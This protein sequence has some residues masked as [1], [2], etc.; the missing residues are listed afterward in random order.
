MPDAMLRM[1][2]AQERR[3]EPEQDAHLEPDVAHQVVVDG[4]THADRLDDGR[5]VVVGQDHDRG[6]LGHLGARDAHGHADV[7]LLERRRVVHA[8]TGHGHDV[9]LRLEHVHQVD[10]VLGR[11]AGDDADVVDGRGDLGRRSWPG[12]RRR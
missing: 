3:D 5:E 8:V 2:G 11:D 7:G 12:T 6:F 10:L 4:A 1:R 9:A